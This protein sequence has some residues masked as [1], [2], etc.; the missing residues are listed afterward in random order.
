M[1]R[2]EAAFIIGV[3]LIAGP[4]LSAVPLAL[5]GLGFLHRPWPSGPLW[6]LPAIGVTV[7]GIV[8]GFNQSSQHRCV[9]VIVGGSR[10]RRVTSSRVFCGVGC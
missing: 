3:A 10:L 7:A 4:L 6:L 5:L 8:G 2:R 1:M 9:G